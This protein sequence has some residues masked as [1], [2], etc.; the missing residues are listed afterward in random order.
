MI[1]LKNFLIISVSQFDSFVRSIGLELSSEADS[2][3][4]T[5]LFANLLAYL[6]I[7]LFIGAVLW[8]YRQLFSK[9]GRDWI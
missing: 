6:I 7:F 1:S 8:L 4:L 9:K 3:V 5:Y 2:Y